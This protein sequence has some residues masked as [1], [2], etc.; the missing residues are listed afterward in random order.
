MSQKEDA[1]GFILRLVLA[2][3][4]VLAFFVNGLIHGEPADPSVNADHQPK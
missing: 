1:V 4:L 2:V 3:V